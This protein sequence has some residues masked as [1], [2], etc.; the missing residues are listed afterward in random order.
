MEEKL[1][2]R[3]SGATAEILNEL[4]KRGY[5]STKSEAIRAG[6]LRLGEAFM[7]IKPPSSYWKELGEEL[8]KS[9]KRMSH[10]EIVEAIASL[11]RE[12]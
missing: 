6:I 10:M 3:L 4:V 5:F 8:K 12:T 9:G 2:V 11:E 7:L 1:L